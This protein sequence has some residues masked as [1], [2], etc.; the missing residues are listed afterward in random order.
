MK[1]YQ[2]QNLT[3]STLQKPRYISALFLET[4]TIPLLVRHWK[5]TDKILSFWQIA[6][7]WQAFLQGIFDLEWAAGQTVWHTTRAQG[8]EFARLSL[9]CGGRQA[10]WRTCRFKHCFRILSLMNIQ[11][12]MQKKKKKN[13][14]IHP[15]L[16]EFCDHLCCASLDS[17]TSATP[18]LFFKVRCHGGSGGSRSSWKPTKQSLQGAKKCVKSNVQAR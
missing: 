17:V 13:Y 1:V 7:S 8:E 18:L 10:R 14:S 11:T 5:D 6:V 12:G 15:Q 16:G 2:F 9:N 4:S 3:R